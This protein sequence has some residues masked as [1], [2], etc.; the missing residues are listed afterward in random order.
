MQEMLNKGMEYLPILLDGIVITVSLTV[1]ALVI[2]TILGLIWAL[3]RYSGIWPL[4]LI[5]KTVVNTVR[6]IPILVQLFYIYFVLPE[7]GIDLTAFE[8]GAIGLGLAYS[9]YMAENFRAGLE[10]IDKGQI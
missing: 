7:F 10:A 2:S 3:M 1:G 8:A 5:S 9:C 4:V 6:G